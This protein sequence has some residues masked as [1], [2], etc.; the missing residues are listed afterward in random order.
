[1]ATS[2]IV[3]LCISVVAV[4][5][6][7]RMS[8]KRPYDVE[9]AVWEGMRHGKP[10]VDSRATTPDFMAVKVCE[11]DA[12]KRVSIWFLDGPLQAGQIDREAGKVPA[13]FASNFR[14]HGKRHPQPTEHAL[15]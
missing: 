5:L 4:S 1:M 14:L 8:R 12:K 6:K 10:D 11:A 3:L 13:Q 7:Y 9:L 2:P 15:L